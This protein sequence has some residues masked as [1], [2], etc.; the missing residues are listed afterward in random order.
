MS[1]NSSPTLHDRAPA[2]SAPEDQF[3]KLIETISRSQQG[4]R[5]LIDHL[6]QAVFTL[7]LEGEIRVANAR[8]SE[9]LGV[10]F[11]DLIGHNLSEFVAEP[12]FE[13]VSK[14]LPAFLSRGS[15]SGRIRVRL[16][17]I[18]EL[19]YFDCYVHAVAE[20]GR[21]VVVSGWARDV[22][23]LHDSQVR[24]AELFESLHEGILFSTPSG[25][26]LDANPALVRMLNYTSKEELQGLNLSELYAD[27]SHR[28]AL[29][30]EIDGKGSVQDVEISLL[31]KGGK[32]IRCLGSARGIRDSSGKL[33]RVQATLRD[34]TEQRLMEHELH[35]EREFGR[36]LIA[37]FPD[38]IA[39]L[40][41]E[42]RF[43]YVSESVRSVLGY[44]A[45]FFL[46]RRLGSQSEAEDRARL[47]AMIERLLSGAS[48][49]DQ[50]EVQAPHADGS[51]RAFRISAA[52]LLDEN[53]KITGIVTSGRDV[54]ESNLHDRQLAEREK[55]TAMGQMLAG[56]AH[57]LN[58][59]LTA[60]LGVSDLLVESSHEEL[61]KRQAG[62]ILKQARRAADIVQN[63]L[64]FSRPRSAGLLPLRIED[65]IQHV[66]LSQR[67]ALEQKGITVQ[68]EAPAGLPPVEAD[69]K[70]LTQVFSNIIVNA[71]QAISSA[72]PAGTIR[73]TIAPSASRVCIAFENDGPAIPAESVGKVF[74]PFFTTKRPGGGSGLGLTICLA[75][76]KDHG[77]TIEVESPQAGGAVFRIYLPAARST[78]AKDTQSMPAAPV[79]SAPPAAAPATG[80]A[81]AQ[82]AVPRTA[83]KI[84]PA[85][86][87]H[88]IV[89]VDDEESILE[90]VQ[91]GLAARGM[92]VTGFS[93]AQEALA[94]LEKDACEVV[95]C[96]FNMPGMKGSELFERLRARAGASAPRFIFMTGELVESSAIAALREQGALTLQ[97][98]FHIP[99][100]TELLVTLFQG[101]VP[102]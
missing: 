84:I 69:R 96:D 23:A 48:V 60:I 75:I 94:H 72:K 85:L 77:G 11:N 19:M 93:N 95:L 12:S 31:R 8:F 15:W 91:E 53:G 14:A 13:N 70:L 32:L 67:S 90:I 38:V 9:I 73:I 45:S 65:V 92:S 59:P 42:A 50:V 18:N 36:R 33:V 10:P 62:L 79:A 44:P 3:Q 41:T 52:P 7:T 81:P 43:T 61:T 83:S 88:S 25:E 16:R 20:S 74:D 101:Q 27:P 82:S 57:E 29:I 58:N 98:P 26:I 76:V 68:F 5:D 35:K 46:G 56:A 30:S 64:A 89:I 97:K 24:S 51:R 40:D 2:A 55:F 6:D 49:R 21:V 17:R 80:T 102:L 37:C 39:L 100:V 86:R 1:T 47:D 87:G 78:S 4:F 34:V 54:T 63:L 66:L 71:E 28:S 99:D 22:T